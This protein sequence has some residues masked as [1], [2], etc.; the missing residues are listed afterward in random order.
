MT[1]CTYTVLSIVCLK[2]FHL[3]T[4]GL[5][6]HLLVKVSYLNWWVV[7]G[8]VWGGGALHDWKL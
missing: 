6:C 4:E 5:F 3:S 8:G 1:L 7:G 2:D